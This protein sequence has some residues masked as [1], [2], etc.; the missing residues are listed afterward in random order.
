MNHLRVIL[1]ITTLLTSAGS[2]AYYECFNP[3]YYMDKLDLKEKSIYINVSEETRAKAHYPETDYVPGQGGDYVQV[4]F[5]NI[6]YTFKNILFYNYGDGDSKVA[7]IGQARNSSGV[8][9]D[10][11]LSFHISHEGVSSGHFY[12]EY[13][14]KRSLN[15]RDREKKI[16]GAYRTQ[17]HTCHWSEWGP[18]LERSSGKGI[19]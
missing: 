8:A 9:R 15:F 10:I 13:G 7:A 2:F 19:H 17:Y 1:L 14:E 3:Q 5:S 11:F 16:N 6:T 18:Y 4:L 12:D